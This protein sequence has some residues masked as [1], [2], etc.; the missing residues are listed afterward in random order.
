M[1]SPPTYAAGVVHFI[2]TP[3]IICSPP[4]S[5][6]CGIS[7]A[8]IRELGC[9]FLHQGIFLTQGLN[10]PILHWQANSLPLSHQ[11][12]KKHECVFFRESWLV[13]R[14]THRHA[15]PP[16]SDMSSPKHR[17]DTAIASLPGPHPS[18]FIA[19]GSEHTAGQAV[20]Q[21]TSN[22]STSRV[23]LTALVHKPGT[24]NT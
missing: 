13:L 10:P 12:T 6:V 1:S 9:H 16:N 20:S 3:W 11:R 8:R 22:K 21:A 19:T 4:G 2:W 24:P 17:V 23:S 18:H 15:Q 5:S 14:G 7:Q